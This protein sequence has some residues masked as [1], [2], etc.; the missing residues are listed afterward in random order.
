MRC[1]DI[2]TGVETSMGKKSFFVV[3]PFDLNEVI[4]ACGEYKTSNEDMLTLMG[5]DQ[6]NQKTHLLLVSID[7]SIAAFREIGEYGLPVLHVGE[8][9][10]P[11]YKY[12]VEGGAEK[13][14][15]V[16]ERDIGPFAA[17]CKTYG[18]KVKSGLKLKVRSDLRG[19]AEFNPVHFAQVREDL[20]KVP[21]V[22]LVWHS[23]LGRKVGDIEG[24]TYEAIRQELAYRF[25]LGENFKLPDFFEDFYNTAGFSLEE[26]RTRQVRAET[27]ADLVFGLYERY[28]K[29][30]ALSLLETRIRDLVKDLDLALEVYVRLYWESFS[31]NTVQGVEEDKFRS[32]T[33]Y[34]IWQII[35][36]LS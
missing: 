15:Q 26:L 27:F 24:K 34:I 13:F 12:A 18:L 2:L 19:F 36:D 20:S 8:A 3:E 11:L 22:N 23:M 32:T 29:I 7:L 10:L 25:E 31:D 14:R 17:E 33:R 28:L 35:C 30:G 21:T 1:A 5:W 6:G 4:G 16:L 9:L